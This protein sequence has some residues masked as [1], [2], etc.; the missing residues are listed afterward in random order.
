MLPGGSRAQA[1]QPRL[2]V[3]SQAKRMHRWQPPAAALLVA[4]PPPA[5]RVHALMLQVAV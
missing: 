5:V 4:G 3:A 2:G 1:L